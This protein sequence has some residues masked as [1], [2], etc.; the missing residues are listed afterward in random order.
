MY[1][2]DQLNVEYQ[3]TIPTTS[4]QE[5]LSI[6]FAPVQK[7]S[8]NICTKILKKCTADILFILCYPFKVMV[9]KFIKFKIF[10]S[11]CILQ[12]SG[13][14]DHF[15]RLCGIQ[16]HQ[17]GSDLRYLH[18]SPALIPKYSVSTLNDYHW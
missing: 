13:G 9:S 12:V 10:K 7:V 6:S 16:L 14:F 2:G 4:G 11:L 15:M 18:L 5:S 8:F 17:L 3:V 1:S